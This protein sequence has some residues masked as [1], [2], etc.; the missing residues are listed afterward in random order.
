MLRLGVFPAGPCR[1]T[2]CA[3]A[4]LRPG[5]LAGSWRVGFAST[6]RLLAGIDDCGLPFGWARDIRPGPHHIPSFRRDRPAMFD[7]AWSEI[8]LIGVV[9]L[10]AIGPKD[11]PVA[12]KT[13]ADLVKKGRRMAGEFQTHVD[14]MV[15]EANLHE[16]RDQV[17]DLRS[18]NIRDQITHAVDGDGTLRRALADDPLRSGDT[19]AWHPGASLAPDAI[20]AE[21]DSA[22][23]GIGL[24]RP[25]A[26]AAPSFLPP[27]TAASEAAHPAIAA[28]AAA[29]SFIPPGAVI[30]GAVVPGGTAPFAAG[31]VAS[32]PADL[33]PSVPRT[34]APDPSMAGVAP[35]GPPASSG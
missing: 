34:S 30:P 13:I 35:A 4:G 22:E 10:V 25:P 11:M 18:F 5:A 32:R 12:I 27:G 23:T 9:A 20:E 33:H 19:A 2:P 8:A 6:A 29:P 7:F 26:A 17:R 3:T 24:P 31:P 15:R 28:R 14:E 16:V 1:A 21:S